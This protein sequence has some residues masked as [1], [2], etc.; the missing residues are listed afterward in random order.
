MFN[1]KMFFPSKCLETKGLELLFFL[2]RTKNNS[3]LQQRKKEKGKVATLPI[4]VD[5]FFRFSAPSMK[6]ELHSIVDV[7]VVTVVVV[8]AAAVVVVPLT[9]LCATFQK[10]QPARH[11][12]EVRLLT[13]FPFLVLA[14]SS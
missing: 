3:K 6:L 10:L 7:F 4:S 2:R 9:R 12:M 13:A 14:Q 11:I 1:K 8:V 5:I